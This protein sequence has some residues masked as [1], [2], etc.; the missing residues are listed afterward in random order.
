VQGPVVS[1][2]RVSR[3]FSRGRE[4]GAL[5]TWAQRAA[6]SARVEREIGR[7]GDWE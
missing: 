6:D 3:V 4:V 7:R 1:G 2:K 5:G